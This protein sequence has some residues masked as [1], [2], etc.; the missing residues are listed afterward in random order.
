MNYPVLFSLCLVFFA[1]YGI[2]FNEQNEEH[3]IPVDNQNEI[4]CDIQI[5]DQNKERDNQIESPY[6]IQGDNQNEYERCSICYDNN[7]DT[8]IG[9]CEHKFCINCIDHWKFNKRTYRCPLCNHVYDNLDFIDNE[10]SANLR[11]NNLRQVQR[12]IYMF[13]GTLVNILSAA[14]RNTNTTTVF[15]A[16]DLSEAIRNINIRSGFTDGIYRVLMNDL[17]EAIRNINTTIDYIANDLMEAIRNINLTSD[18]IDGIYRVLI[19]MLFDAIRNNNRTSVFTVNDIHEAIRNL[20]TTRNNI[21]HILFQA[22]RNINTPSGFIDGIYQVLINKLLEA[23]RNNNRTS[24]FT[25]NILS[26][27]IRNSNIT[28]VIT[29]NDLS[30]AIR[31]I[32]TPSGFTD[33]IYRVL[34]NDLAEAIRNSNMTTDNIGGYSRVMINLASEV[35][36][37][38]NFTSIFIANNLH[39]ARN[40]STT[41]DNIANDLS[42]AI[43]NVNMTRDIIVNLLSIAMRNTNRTSVFTDANMTPQET[44]ED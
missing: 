37:N 38:T 8:P 12:Y 25:V 39:G 5:D 4:T 21:I 40:I 7:Q 18:N 16:N 42:E 43:R 6:D 13:A 23:I 20:D 36:R 44:R 15:T 1:A 22:M 41:R 30:E 24:V 28:R 2:P 14:I 34:I 27:A 3:S 32:N 9:E 10:L 11:I 26:T 35:M 17:A 29:A 33:G 31:N 19:I